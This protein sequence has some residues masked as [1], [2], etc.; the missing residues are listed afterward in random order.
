MTGYLCC[1]GGPLDGKW[2]LPG[3][4][5]PEGGRVTLTYHPNGFYERVVDLLVWRD[6]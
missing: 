6:L 2:L 5:V 4:D 1:F 3:D